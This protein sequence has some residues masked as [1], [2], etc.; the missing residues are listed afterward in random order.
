[1]KTTTPRIVQSRSRSVYFWLLLPLLL[2]VL[3]LLGWGDYIRIQPPAPDRVKPLQDRLAEQSRQIVLLEEERR[4]LRE[5]LAVREH[6]SQVDQEAIRQVREELKQSQLRY[7]EM[8]KE[9][10]LLRDV[11]ESSATTPGLYIQGFRVD[12]VD[13]GEGY[14]YRFTVSQALKNA[15]YAEGWI[16]LAVEGERDGQREILP[17]KTLSESENERLKM[18]FR[19][20]QDVDG[21]LQIPGD[22][23]PER[24]IVEIETNNDSL[25]GV[26][27]AFDWLV[28]R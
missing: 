23:V 7:R 24:V 17:L 8:E 14:R 10:S 18:R 21:Q 1:M 28:I 5:Q 3:V 11:V 4:N 27:K 2:I 9:L 19:H 25:P 12:S 13:G 20:F 16:R 22:F 26:K 15:G 6:A